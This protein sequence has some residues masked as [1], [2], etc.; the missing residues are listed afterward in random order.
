MCV[1]CFEV[2]ATG[3]ELSL[4]VEDG[5]VVVGTSLAVIHPGR[6]CDAP[7]VRQLPTAELHSLAVSL[8]V[9]N[10]TVGI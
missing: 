7:G 8:C 5:L 4:K 1:V 3:N 6:G 2:E 10:K 9:F